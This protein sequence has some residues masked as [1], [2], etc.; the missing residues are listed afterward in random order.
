MKKSKAE[1]IK[2]IADSVSTVLVTSAE[3]RV[4]DLLGFECTRISPS[5]FPKEHSFIEFSRDTSR[6][7][8]VVTIGHNMY[9]FKFPQSIVDQLPPSPRKLGMLATILID[10]HPKEGMSLQDM[11]DTH[12]EYLS[13]LCSTPGYHA[14]CLHEL[15][16]VIDATK[17]A[18]EFTSKRLPIPMPQGIRDRLNTVYSWK[19]RLQAKMMELLAP[20]PKK[21]TLSEAMEEL[22]EQ[23][24]KDAGAP[25]YFRRPSSL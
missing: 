3:Q 19:P 11:F 20:Q 15:I 8:Q 13:R 1:R 16:Y 17:A 7:T 12:M 10:T 4:L 14:A 5:S 9:H 6:G 2:E 21:Q 22:F 23:I 25:T 18:D 24:I